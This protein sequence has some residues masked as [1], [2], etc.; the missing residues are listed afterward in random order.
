[1]HNVLH[2]GAVLLAITFSSPSSPTT[3]RARLWPEP[4]TATELL[5][6]TPAC[7]PAH[8]SQYI[9]DESEKQAQDKTRPVVSTCRRARLAQHAQALYL[10]K[11][12]CLAPFHTAPSPMPCT[13]LP[14]TQV[15]PSQPIY[16]RRR[17]LRASACSSSSASPPPSFRA[18]FLPHMTKPSVASKLAEANHPVAVPPQCGCRCSWPARR[19]HRRHRCHRPARRRRRPPPPS[20]SP[21]P[22]SPCVARPSADDA[23]LWPAGTASSSS[24]PT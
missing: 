20:P 18:T 23:T 14:S 24:P 1:M 15:P 22:P 5:R 13:V 9:D 11:P 21:P 17:T 16:R 19:R 6:F 7:C 4:H 10:M 2:C 3:R 12:S 8:S